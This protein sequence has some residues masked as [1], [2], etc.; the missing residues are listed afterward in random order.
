MDK[1]TVREKTALY[2]LKGFIT[3][4]FTA[5]LYYIWVKFYNPTIPTPFYR[6]GNYLLTAVFL[7]AYLGFTKIYGAFNIGSAPLVDIIYSQVV[8]VGFLTGVAYITFS[9]LSYKMLNIFPFA[10]IFLLF[11]VFAALWSFVTDAVY[12]KIHAPKKTLVVFNNYDSYLS[13]KGIRSMDRRFNV[14]ETVNSENIS[15]NDIYEKVDRVKAVFLCGVPSDYRNEIVKYCIATN[16]VAYVKPKI[17]DC[18]LRGGKTIQLMNVPVYRCKRNSSSILY[19]G[20]KRA[21]DVIISVVGI[22][23]TSPVTAATAIAIKKEDGGPVFYRQKRLTYNGKEFY[24]FKFRSMR[25]NAEK[26][27]VAR[28]ASDNDDRITKVGGI[29]RKMRIDELPQLL[30]I[31]KGDMSFVGPRPERPEIAAQYEKE[32]PEFALRLQVKAGLTGYAQ[33]YG[34][35]NTPP[36]DKVLMDLMYIANQSVIEDLRLI[37]MTLKIVFTPSST[38]G[39]QDGQITAQN[40][41]NPNDEN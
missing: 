8:S 10:A 40:H 7:V 41:E 6:Q 12:F 27:G 31:L 1:I 20:I 25:V 29:I 4:V 16:R 23:I 30:N 11:S 14:V 2:T 17:S 22:I 26:D 28:L 33:I 37:I 3:I 39:I 15:L 18:I 24:V 21:F 35:Y 9:L 32:M 19:Q 38:E 34:K 5:S 13:L 36:Y